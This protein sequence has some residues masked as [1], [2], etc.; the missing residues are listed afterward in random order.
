M[1]I[2]WRT[3]PPPYR[4][5][6]DTVQKVSFVFYLLCGG[7]E[8]ART[9]Y[10]T[11]ANRTLSQM[12]YIPTCFVK[13]YITSIQFHISIVSKLQRIV[14]RQRIH[15]DFNSKTEISGYEKNLNGTITQP[16]PLE[17]YPLKP[18]YSYAPFR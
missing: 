13:Y 16:N 3:S 10:L 15:S 11:D 9:L 17:I 7:D 6:K 2:W 18:R 4:K 12:S 14:E 8:E 1:V 5:T